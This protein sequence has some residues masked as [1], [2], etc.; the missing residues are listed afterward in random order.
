MKTN[1]R[2]KVIKRMSVWLVVAL[3]VQLFVVG[4]NSIYGAENTINEDY[5]TVRVE[6]ETET[7]FNRNIKYSSDFDTPLAVLREAIG[8]DNITGTDSSFGYY[9]TG[10]LSEESTSH[11][12][13]MYFVVDNSNQI[14]QPMVG[15]D[16]FD[17]LTNADGERIVKE[18]VFYIS[19]YSGASIITK[20]PIIKLT[21]NGN[22]YTLTV[23]KNEVGNTAIENVNVKVSGIGQYKTDDN[24]QINFTLDQSGIYHVEISKDTTF[25]EI[26]RNQFVINHNISSDTSGVVRNAIDRLRVHYEDKEVNGHVALALNATLDDM[27]KKKTSFK[28]NTDNDARGVAENIIGA[29]ATGQDADT[30][31]NQLLDSQNSDGK[32]EVTSSDVNEVLAQVDAI[33]ALDM[34]KA[35]YD[36]NGAILSLLGMATNGHY[37]REG[38][39]PDITIT[40]QAMTALAPHRSISGVNEMI[41]SCMAFLKNR[42][43]ASTGGFDYDMF[44]DT[45]ASTSNQSVDVT[46]SIN[47]PYTNAAV[48]QGIVAVQDAPLGEDWT[49]GAETILGALMDSQLEDG[50]FDSMGWSMSDSGSNQYALLGLASLLEGETLYQTVETE[51]E[52]EDDNDNE[53]DTVLIDEAING[54]KDYLNSMETRMDSSYQ[55][56]P[57][58]YRALEVIGLN[59]ISDDITKDVEILAEKF[60]INTTT[61]TLPYALNIIGLYGSGQNPQKYIDLL[62]EGQQEDG[63]FKIGKVEQT[64]WSMIALDMSGGSYN[65]EKAATFIMDDFE[66]EKSVAMLAIAVTALANH[67]DVVGVEAFIN[68]KLEVIRQKQKESGGFESVDGYGEDSQALSFVISALVANGI[69]PLTNTEWQKNDKTMLDALLEYKKLNY[70]IYNDTYGDYIYKDEATEQ[71]LIALIDLK[72]GKSTYSNV[73]YCESYKAKIVTALF[74]L[75]DYLETSEKRINTSQMEVDMYYTWQE[76]A[77]LNY[78]DDD[79]ETLYAKLQEKYTLNNKAS[80]LDISEDIIAL[81][82]SGQILSQL[83]TDY[84]AQL[85]ALQQLDGT[86]VKEGESGNVYQQSMGIIAMDM[87]NGNYNE[88]TAVDS[89]ISMSADGHFDDVEQT[90]W[91]LIALS[92]HGDISGVTDLIET[93]LEYLK[94]QQ[95]DNGGYDLYSMG[96]AT[97]YTSVAI[98]ALIANGEN[99][100]DD[101]WKKSG[102]TMIDSMLN[103]Q[104]ENGTF[105]LMKGWGVDVASTSSSLAALADLYHGKSLY[106]VLEPQLDPSETIKNTIKELKSYYEEDSYYNYL[107]VLGLYRSEADANIL[108]SKFELRQDEAD[109]IYIIFDNDV[110]MLAKDIMGIIGIG[111]KPRDYNNKDYVQTLLDTQN[112]EGQFVLTDQSNIGAQANSIIA[113]SMAGADYNKEKAVEALISAYDS[114]SKPS[115]Y[116]ISETIIALSTVK[117]ISGVNDKID[118]C[119]EDMKKCQLPSAGFDYNDASSFTASEVSEY[120]AVALQAIVAAGKDYKSDEF[121]KNGQ[122]IVDAMMAFKNDDHFIYDSTK[123]S[124]KDYTDLATGAVL[125]A[126]I[127]IDTEESMFKAL[128]IIDAPPMPLTDEERVKQELEALINYYSTDSIFSFRE[129][130]GYRVTS[131]DEQQVMPVIAGRFTVST[132]MKQASDYVGNIIGLISSGKNPRDYNDINYV[133]ELADLQKDEGIF[134]VGSEGAYVTQTAWSMIALYMS[135]AQDLFDTQKGVESIIGFQQADGGFGAVDDTAMSLLALSLYKDMEGAEAAIDNAI[136]YLK[137]KQLNTAGF[138]YND[139]FAD[140]NIWSISAVIQALVAAGKNPL[141]DE[142]KK[143]GVSMVDA[144]LSFKGEGDFG[145]D[146][147]REQVFLALADLEKG[148]SMYAELKVVE[149]TEPAQF[150]IERIGNSLY[151]NGEEAL[152]KIEV[153]NVSD[154]ISD[155]LLIVLLVDK[156]TNQL[157]NYT[158]IMEAFDAKQNHEMAAGL[159]IPEVGDYEIRAYVWDNFENQK[160]LMDQPIIVEVQ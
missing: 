131:T 125:A 121:M 99:P 160:V 14:I 114:E 2:T 147:A 128:T 67:K 124:Y 42:Q 13:W 126:L 115:I 87:A 23:T 52:D 59:S 109:R 38:A 69:D 15:V 37:P 104:L 79:V 7:L 25:P 95:S 122:T 47:S 106:Q 18:L 5:I 36:E 33:L 118:D 44:S 72:N 16:A 91:A 40:A 82:A 3:I 136:Q 84:V 113:L 78:S 153:K 9:I 146:S 48:I 12:G 98:Q 58:F 17:G 31:V 34:A 152:I 145:N 71:A 154:E 6:G 70:F 137:S 30:Y 35:S 150:D 1:G 144:L 63:S 97:Q 19:A 88:T 61:G 49:K 22:D 66:N 41:D 56:K 39:Y 142:W 148:T 151:H 76:V 140:E 85:E 119:F 134:E 157:L 116:A 4:P 102:K 149:V 133:K 77:A 73:Q 80:V 101:E 10:I 11:T 46:P 8:E 68:E 27:S 75:K 60:M 130:I 65:I 103:H 110:E 159:L 132:D 26:V 20:I 94:S 86:F 89:L 135:N 64:I 43:Y 107:Q 129:S 120:D 100:L 28:V 138:G 74:K 123:K 45:T 29:I 111:E 92:N 62:V 143:N 93:S 83:N 90:S 105:E 51:D 155:A 54:I 141:A 81:I 108:A 53:N 112:T 24:G 21:S 127:D 117:H 50:T 156:D 139:T 96:D 158:Y 55:S 57:F 32:F